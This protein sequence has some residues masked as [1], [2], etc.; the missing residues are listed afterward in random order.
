MLCDA[1]TSSGRHF[2]PRLAPRGFASG[3]IGLQRAMWHRP[4]HWHES[5]RTAW[6]TILECAVSNLDVARAQQLVR[7][8]ELAGWRRGEE[9]RLVVAREAR[10][11]LL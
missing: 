4:S 10:L 11:K 9:A 3:P 1:Q 5:V 6:Q 7:R 8:A 2:V